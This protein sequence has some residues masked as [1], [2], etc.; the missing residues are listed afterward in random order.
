[1]RPR[2]ETLTS[3]AISRGTVAAVVVSLL[4]EWAGVN[5][6]EPPAVVAVAEITTFSAALCMNETKNTFDVASSEN[7]DFGFPLRGLEGGS[8]LLQ[9]SRRH[10]F[11][12]R[13][14]SSQDFVGTGSIGCEGR[15]GTFVARTH[16]TNVKRI[17]SVSS[18]DGGRG[19]GSTS[20]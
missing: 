4:N 6:T 8:P 16:F 10:S 15:D 1:M 13:I 19:D 20:L 3:R 2:Q 17:R 9:F 7:R 12:G 14:G 5:V 18:W 11:F